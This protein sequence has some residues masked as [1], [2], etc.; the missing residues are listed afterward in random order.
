MGTRF[1]GDLEEE[2]EAQEEQGVAVRKR[3]ATARNRIDGKRL[4]GDNLARGGTSR[5]PWRRVTGVPTAKRWFFE[6]W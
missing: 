3:A 5:G 1:H 4:E 6:G 2:I